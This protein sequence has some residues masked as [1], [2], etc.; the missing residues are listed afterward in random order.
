MMEQNRQGKPSHRQR[1][2][3]KRLRRWWLIGSG[4]VAA[5]YAIDPNWPYN[6]RRLAVTIAIW[7]RGSLGSSRP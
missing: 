5:M 3:Q 7:I 1:T 2:Y 4:I 6:F